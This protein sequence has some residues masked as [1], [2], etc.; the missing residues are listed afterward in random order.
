MIGSIIGTFIPIPIIGSFGSFLG[1]SRAAPR[2]PFGSHPSWGESDVRVVD[3]ILQ[4]AEW[5]G[6]GKALQVASQLAGA[7]TGFETSIIRLIGGRITGVDTLTVGMTEATRTTYA[8][9]GGAQ[10]QGDGATMIEQAAIAQLKTA[11]IAG[12]DVL[13]K[14]ALKNTDAHTRQDVNADRALA[15]TYAL[16]ND[17][18]AFFNAHVDELMAGHGAAAAWAAQKARAEGQLDLD[19]AFTAAVYRANSETPRWNIGATTAL[20]SIASRTEPPPTP[21]A[22]GKAT[23]A[24]SAPL[25]ALDLNRDG[26]IAQGAGQAGALFDIDGDGFREQTGWLTPFDGFLVFDRNHN[27]EIDSIAEMA[28]SQRAAFRH[29]AVDPGYRPRWLFPDADDAEFL[30]CP[31]VDRPQP[32]RLRRHRRAVVADPLQHRSSVP[33]GYRRV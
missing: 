23:M 15:G 21:P 6:E 11:R 4:P 29:R 20:S 16:Y 28:V 32:Q 14:Q 12:G 9:V 19:G 22:L 24:F 33:V 31:G 10:F 18:A 3:G 27:G 17:N 7:A 8:R 1:C 5:R 30:Q 13:S 26:V 2:Q 25:I